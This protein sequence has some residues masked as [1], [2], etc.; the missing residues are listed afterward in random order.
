MNILITGGAGFIGSAVIR[1]AIKQGHRVVNLDMLTYAACIENL[2]TVFDHPKYA[3]EKVD[4]RNR[5]SLDDIFSKYQPEVVLHLAAESH[6]DRSIDGPSN[7]IETNIVGT[8]NLL[9]SS[10]T[11]WK[12]KGYP[13]NF[14]FHHISTDEVFGSLSVNS[15]IKF[16]ETTA[17]DPQSPYSASKAC[18]DH[19][20]QAWHKTYKLPIIITNC[21]NNYGPYQFPEKLI[22]VIIL[23]ALN[24]EPLPVYGDGSNIRDWLHVEDHAEA[25]LLVLGKGTVGRRYNIGADNEH[26]NIDVVKTLC[27]ILNRIKPRAKGSY[28]DLI[29][30]V[31]DRPGHDKRYAVDASRIKNELGWTPKITFKDGL[32]KTVKWYMQNRKWWE[33][34]LSRE[35]VGKR[36]GK[37]DSRIR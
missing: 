24:C 34:L 2:N 16:T 8:F 12:K 32:E 36:L 22:P 27:E 3:F 1:M 5:S 20:V 25:L 7:F 33:P 31:T 13:K 21:S 11:Y 10:L 28:L 19:L 17:Y 15:S 26:S 30:F 9:Q 29:T 35:G 18:S 37:N 23:N 4:I 14:R 6:V